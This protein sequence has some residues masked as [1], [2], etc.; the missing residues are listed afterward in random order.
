M[1]KQLKK[2]NGNSTSVNISQLPISVKKEMEV[3]YNQTEDEIQY[4]QH[5]VNKQT[6]FSSSA[7]QTSNDK[8]LPMKQV[9]R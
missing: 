1:V 8:T 4:G 7:D 9:Y 3:T 5:F 2:L 6:T